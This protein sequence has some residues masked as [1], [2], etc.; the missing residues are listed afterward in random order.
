[1]WSCERLESEYAKLIMQ[2]NRELKKRCVD[3]VLESRK[4]ENKTYYKKNNRSLIYE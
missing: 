1:M 4:L 3:I 2:C